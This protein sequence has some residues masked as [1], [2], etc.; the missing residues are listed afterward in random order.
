VQTIKSDLTVTPG[1][2][3]T[4]SRWTGKLSVDNKRRKLMNKKGKNG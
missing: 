3:S 4:T 2:Q 1:G